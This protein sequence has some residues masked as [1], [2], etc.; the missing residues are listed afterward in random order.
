MAHSNE[1]NIGN[2]ENNNPVTLLPCSDGV[3]TGNK[4]RQAL[5]KKG[6]RKLRSTAPTHHQ[7]P[8]RNSPVICLS[9]HN[10]NTLTASPASRAAAQAGT[11][12]PAGTQPGLSLRHVK[13]GARREVG[14]RV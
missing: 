3:N 6:G 1:A 2:V 10:N 12:H 14:A 11:E 9:D 8:P 5:V 7:K 4:A 13:Q